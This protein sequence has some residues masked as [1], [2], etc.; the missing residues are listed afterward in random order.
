[1]IAPPILDRARGVTIAEA[2]ALL[3]LK[4]P[5]A[6]ELIGPC[7]ACGGRDRFSINSRKRLWNCLGALGGNDSLGL[8]QHVLGLDFKGA[9]EFLTGAR[10]FAPAPQPRPALQPASDEDDATKIARAQQLA[11]E[12]Q[13]VRGTIAEVYL[14]I[15]RKLGAIDPG[16]AQS[17]RF[18]ARLAMRNPDDELV[19]VPALVAIMRDVSATFDKLARERGTVAE[20]E[21]AVLRDES[22]IRAVSC[23]ALS[24]D[25][26]AKR[27]GPKSRKFRGVAKGAGVVFGDLWSMFYGGGELHVAE[28]VETALA[29]RRLFNAE[30]VV[31]LGSAGAIRDFE[32][33]PCVQRLVIH[34]ERDANGTSERAAIECY[35]RWRQHISNVEIIAPRASCDANDVLMQEAG[36]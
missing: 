33:L 22:L 13:D 21:A 20:A 24:D 26:R 34:A 36:A 35:R 27:F 18:H 17:L 28:G 12:G 6:G 2:A 4:V 8:V 14:A 32:Y 30:L 29:V 23:L 3:G 11:R 5:R 1:M 16:A 7:P 25:G 9:V 31:A 10:E 15:V 19:R